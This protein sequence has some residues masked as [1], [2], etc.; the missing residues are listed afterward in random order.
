MPNKKAAFKSFRQ[1]KKKNVRNKAVLSEIRTLTKKARAF[2]TSKNR[3]EGD[4]T[5]KSLES[6]LARAAKNKIIKKQT[7]SRRISRLR[8]QWS[9]PADKATA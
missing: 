6:K 8:V 3:E 2:I 4:T 7:A 1:D 5:L 9:K